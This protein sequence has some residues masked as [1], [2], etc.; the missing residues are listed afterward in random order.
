MSKDFLKTP[1][2][3][4]FDAAGRPQFGNFAGAI[5]DLNYEQFD[6]KVLE[7]W[8]WTANDALAAKLLKRW[9]F[10]GVIDDGL[11]LGGA[12]VHL[13]YVGTGFAYVY[14]R[15]TGVI[16]EKNLKMPLARNTMFSPSAMNGVSEIRRGDQ[17]IR[18]DNTCRQGERRVDLRCG[19]ELSADITYRE[20]GTGV[21]TVAH[22]SL[23]GFGHTYK[24]IGLPAEGSVTVQGREMNL[25]PR[26]MAILDWSCATPPRQTVWNWAAAVGTDQKGRA[27]GINFSTGLIAAGFTENTVWLEG[28]PTMINAIHFAYDRGDI[29]GKP[30][31]VG[32]AAGDV[33]LSFQPERERHEFVNFGVVKSRFHQP[34][35]RFSGTILLGR[36]KCEVDLYGFC[37]EH[38]A[39]W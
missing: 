16:T 28:K 3:R 26:A 11:V 9:E 30:W 7:R 21:T 38:F 6:F 36:E 24:F 35:G 32:T 37:E 25:T 1:P 20:N 12:V 19:S 27:V 4:L 10:V 2:D 13:H 29:V 17:F 33:D 18:L 39:K 8:P 23:V 34:F 15:Q 5:A 14:D 22:Q 31:Q